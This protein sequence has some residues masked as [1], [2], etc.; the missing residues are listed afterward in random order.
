MQ[1]SLEIQKNNASYEL[2]HCYANP[3]DGIKPINT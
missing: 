2:V 1:I 3:T